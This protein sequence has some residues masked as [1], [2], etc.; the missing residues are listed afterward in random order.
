MKAELLNASLPAASLC[1]GCSWDDKAQ[2]LIWIDITGRTIHRYHPASGKFDRCQT[3]SSIGFAALAES[4]KY[5]AGLQDGLY[6][7]DFDTGAATPL[8][9]PDYADRNNRFNDGKCDRR[10]RLWAGTMNDVDH[11][12]ATGAFYRYDDRG[13]S[14]QETGIYISNGLGWSPDDKI[15]YYTDTGRDTIWKYD[16]DI[17]TGEATNRRVFV[18]LSGKG[19]PDGMC[20]DAQ[21]RVFTAQW[22]GWCVKI[23]T[24]DGKPDGEIRVDAPQVSCCAFGGDDMK[25]LFITNASIGLSPQQMKEAPLA[26]QVFAIHMDAPGQRQSRFKG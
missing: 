16:Y 12:K 6:L 24:P 25:T 19:H 13:L 10:G 14:V 17:E 9:H 5:A 4:G 1:E 22:G 26:G 7:V 21:G 15:M 2:R 23:F 11:K 18:D 20:V 8:V 3:P